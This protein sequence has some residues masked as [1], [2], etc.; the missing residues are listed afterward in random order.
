MELTSQKQ[1]S[2]K[3]QIHLDI[4]R[5]HACNIIFPLRF[6]CLPIFA[7][8]VCETI[9]VEYFQ[10]HC[11]VCCEMNFKSFFGVR[12]RARAKKAFTWNFHIQLGGY[13]EMYT[14]QTFLS[15]EEGH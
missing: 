2:N 7:P 15:F 14:M 13:C 3:K 8:F 5:V 10:S 4:I 12:L 9:H 6:L 1:Y 11:A